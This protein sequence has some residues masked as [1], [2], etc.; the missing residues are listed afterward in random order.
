MVLLMFMAYVYD[1]C[2]SGFLRCIINLLNNKCVETEINCVQS[3]AFYTP[4]EHQWYGSNFSSHSHDCDIR[5][6]NAQ[7][8]V[9]SVSAMLE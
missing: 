2:K 9:C 3:L 6:L 4:H 8:F 5:L 7:T 1:L